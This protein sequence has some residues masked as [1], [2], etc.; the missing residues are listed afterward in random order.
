MKT[1]KQS[2]NGTWQDLL[3]QLELSTLTSRYRCFFQIKIFYNDLSYPPDITRVVFLKCRCIKSPDHR[4]T[5]HIIKILYKVNL[6]VHVISCRKHKLPRRKW[7]S[8]KMKNVRIDYSHKSEFQENLECEDSI[9]VS[10]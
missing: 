3:L 1:N 4:S 9:Q 7:C 6:M 8:K 10:S 5:W 2:F